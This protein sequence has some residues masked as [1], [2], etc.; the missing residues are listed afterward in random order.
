MI[1]EMLFGY[2][3]DQL[4]GKMLDKAALSQRV[5]SSNVANAETPG[6]QRKGVSFDQELLRAVAADRM[7]VKRTNPKHMPDPNWVENIEPEVVEIEDG[8]WNG[9]NNVDIEREMVDLAKA[10]LD[11]SMA[12]KLLNSRFTGLRTAIRGRR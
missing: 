7:P 12:S 5:I 3:P 1:K 10:Q 2:R 8:Y 6:Y 11:F 9:V 4:L